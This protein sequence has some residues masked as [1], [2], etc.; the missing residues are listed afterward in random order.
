MKKGV[1]VD[2]KIICII[3]IYLMYLICVY[4]IFY[5]IYMIICYRLQVY[6]QFILYDSNINYI[7]RSYFF[8]KMLGDQYVSIYRV[9]N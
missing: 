5:C 7:D 1:V 9:V 4:K 2:L 8:F 6:M 3:N